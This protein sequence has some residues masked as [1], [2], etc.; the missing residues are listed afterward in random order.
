MPVIDRP[1]TDVQRL[2]ALEAAKLRAD[3]IPPGDLPFSA[4][5]LAALLA[6]LPIF[7]TEMQ[8]R[9]SALSAQAASTSVADAAKELLKMFISHFF[10]VFNLGIERNDYT[11]DQRA[12]F[13]LNVNQ[14][15]LPELSTEMQ[16]HTWANRIV[17]GD[18]ARV[19]AGGA[20]MSN[21]T[22]AQVGTKLTAYVTAQGA[23]SVKKGEY[24]LEQEDVEGLRPQADEII[25]DIW[26]ES[27]FTYRKETPSS[28]RR[29]CREVGVV[30]R[31][32]P[33]ETLSPEDFSITGTAT[34]SATNAPIG[35]V[36]VRVSL[37]AVEVFVLTNE[38]GKYFVPVLDP[39]NYLLQ[40][41]K[42]GYQNYTANNVPASA[43]EVTTHNIPLVEGA[44]ATGT[45]SGQV[46]IGPGNV[47]ANVIV[48]G[49][50]LSANTD[51]SNNYILTDVPTGTQNVTATAIGNPSQT[52]TLPVVVTEGATVVLNFNI[53]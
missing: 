45:I 25:A 14:E 52:Q 41:H 10:Q 26:D 29:K 13:Q 47:P 12:H 34:D 20:A 8:Q 5:T 9:G 38:L 2:Q 44:E 43:T 31:P 49:T 15:E 16:I 51:P 35:G 48:E 21:P 28:K 4:A 6:F 30:Y 7:R 40:A 42:T 33:G 19:A 23:Q 39:G 3:L 24:D 32:R 17:N 46:I 50:G 37:G 11:A 22:A 27:E 18:A 53:P 1:N 36:L